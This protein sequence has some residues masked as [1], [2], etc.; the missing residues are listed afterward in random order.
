MKMRLKLPG[1]RNLVLPSHTVLLLQESKVRVS[2]P[3]VQDKDVALIHGELQ[4]SALLCSLAGQAVSASAPC[5]PQSM[6]C[7]PR[8]DGTHG[9]PRSGG[10]EEEDLGHAI[11][12]S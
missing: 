4:A 12:E 10:M 7:A 11:V 3:Y 2:F 6:P 9:V 5:E 1:M 8:A